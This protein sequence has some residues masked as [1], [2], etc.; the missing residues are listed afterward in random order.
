VTPSVSAFTK[1]TDKNFEQAKALWKVKG[2]QDGAQARFMDN[3]AA[4]LRDMRQQ[5]YGKPSCCPANLSQSTADV[6][7]LTACPEKCLPRSKR[8]GRKGRQGDRA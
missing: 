7:E 6:P 2:K 3:L 5:V 4:H 8:N 1:V